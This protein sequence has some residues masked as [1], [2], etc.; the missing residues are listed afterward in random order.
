MHACL[1]Y[2]SSL[3]MNFEFLDKDLLTK[4]K[5]AA[6]AFSITRTKGFA[7][8]LESHRSE[9]NGESQT[10]WSSNQI[11]ILDIVS[12]LSKQ[13]PKS[14]GLQ[15]TFFRLGLDSINAVQIAA[16]LKQRGLKVSPIEVLEV[17][18]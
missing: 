4:T 15:T 13:Q 12:K 10:R 18:L 11:E 5:S 6:N 2:P 8:S 16:Q 1:R 9:P 17:V 3:V 14:I 7:R